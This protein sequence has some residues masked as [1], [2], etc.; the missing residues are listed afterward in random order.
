MEKISRRSFLK[1]AGITGAS[2]AMFACSSSSD[3]TS[4]SGSSASVSGDAPTIRVVTSSSSEKTA[5]IFRDQLIKAGFNVELNLQ[6]DTSGLTAILFAGSYDV[7]LQGWTTAAGNPDYAVRSFFYSTG[8]ANYLGLNDATVDELMDLGASQT[9]EEY[10]DTYSELEQYMTVEQAVMVPLYG[11]MVMAAWNKTVVDS[12]SI[13]MRV[14]GM[15]G[16]ES[17][18]YVNAADNDTRVL[19]ITQSAGTSDS[20]HTIQNN[21]YLTKDINENTS[22]RLLNLTADNEITKESALSIEYVV[23][24]GN[25]SFY[26]LLRDDVN[27]SK[28][29]DGGTADTGVLVAAEDVKFSLEQA[30]DPSAVDGQIVYSLFENFDTI[31]VV[32]DIEVLKETL[33]S[34]STQTVYDYLNA[35]APTN[36]DSIEPTRDTVDNAGGK[37]QVVK[38]TTLGAFPQALN[39]LTH[40]GAGILNEENVMQYNSLVDMANYDPTV[41]V[42]FG[43]AA[44]VTEGATYDNQMWFSGPYSL[45]SKNDYIFTIEKNDAFMPGTEYAP[46]IRHI[47][48]NIIGDD[49]SAS[50]S[51]RSGSLDI[52]PDVGED[53]YDVI[54]AEDTFEIFKKSANSVMMGLF[55]RIEGLTECVDSDL[56]LAIYHAVCQ[57]DYV[58]V[59]NNLVEKVASPVST[60]LDTGFEHAYDLDLATEYLATYMSK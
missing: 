33:V 18:S 43:D 8:S 2:A 52:L 46:K 53:Y 37:Y 21:S 16:W 42:L 45:V 14:S 56:R 38:I 31:D 5:N 27:F 30:K 26:F 57:D 24:E 15:M 49:A 32:E 50:S 34:G 13:N 44:L 12:D 19:N 28:V 60:V 4:A 22:I 51:L 17:I 58:A 1:A 59:Y 48:S 6:A 29:V 3:T 55:N 25:E 7:F 9:A 23:A 10:F 20:Y 35:A 40:T 54:A 41:D 39:F 47:V 36:I 11:Y